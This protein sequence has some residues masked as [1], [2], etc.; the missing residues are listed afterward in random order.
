M[1]PDVRTAVTR[2]AVRSATR[3]KYDPRAVH[4]GS[5]AGRLV[6][7]GIVLAVI[8]LATWPSDERPRSPR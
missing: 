3:E 4:S 1:L 6:G 2:A 5:T 8:V 7:I